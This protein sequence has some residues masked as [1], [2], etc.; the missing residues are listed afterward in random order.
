MVERSSKNESNSLSLSSSPSLSIK[1]SSC[2]PKSSSKSS[3]PSSPSSFSSA[4]FCTILMNYDEY[5]LNKFKK[6]K[7]FS[8]FYLAYKKDTTLSKLNHRDRLRLG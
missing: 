6:L 5:F 1:E 4:I 3:R 2:S 8:C 7:H